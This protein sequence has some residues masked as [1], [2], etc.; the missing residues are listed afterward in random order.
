M[1]NQN[2]QPEFYTTRHAFTTA[3]TMG[4]V[5][6]VQI[7]TN[8]SFN[9]E[10]RIYGLM[11]TAVDVN[12]NELNY[13]GSANVRNFDISIQAGPNRIPSTAMDGGRIIRAEDR[14]LAFSSPVLVLHRQPLQVSLE[15]T[16]GSAPSANLTFVITLISEMYIREA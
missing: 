16:G 13:A 7:Y 1:V 15:W 5:K 3:D 14:T 8:Q 10:V 11:V 4:S 12:G 2:P 6:A 9:E